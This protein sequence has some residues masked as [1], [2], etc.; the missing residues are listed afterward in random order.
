MKLTLRKMQAN[1][2]TNTGTENIMTDASAIGRYL[3][4]ENRRNSEV[5]PAMPLNT[6]KC[7]NSGGPNG[8]LPFLMTRGRVKTNIPMNLNTA[9]SPGCMSC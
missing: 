3:N 6:R 2:E 9:N 5:A 7:R 4:A 8:L 1:N